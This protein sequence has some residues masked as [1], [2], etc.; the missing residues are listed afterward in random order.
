M[1]LDYKCTVK[2]VV[3]DHP[4]GPRKV[5]LYDRWSFIRGIN[6]EM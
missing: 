3:I 4:T 6:I 2:P 1:I 5:V